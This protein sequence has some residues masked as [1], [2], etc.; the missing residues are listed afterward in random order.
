MIKL[1]K[2][3]A[4]GVP[5]HFHDRKVFFLA[6]WDELFANKIIQADK[7]I[8]PR[9]LRIRLVFISSGN[10]WEKFQEILYRKKV[11]KFGKGSSCCWKTIYNEE[12]FSHFRQQI[13]KFGF[14]DFIGDKCQGLEIKRKFFVSSLIAEKNPFLKN[15][16][17]KA[18]I[19]AYSAGY[20]QEHAE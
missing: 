12:E 2:I 14:I 17:M 13:K 16:R 10:W 15:F 3:S 8:F 6:C 18:Q 7:E 5:I 20:Q 4:K 1:R 11:W 9:Y 19:K